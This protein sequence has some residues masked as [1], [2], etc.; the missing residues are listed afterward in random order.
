MIIDG[1]I[2]QFFRNFFRDGRAQ[3]FL[4]VGDGGETENLLMRYLACYDKS[5]CKKCEACQSESFLGARVYEG[6]S[7]KIEDAR[8]IQF[9]AN[10][11]A[12][13]G[14]KI[15]RIKSGYLAPDAQTTLLKTI[16]EPHPE[17]Y[18]VISLASDASLSLP[19]L[20]RLTV[21]KKSK[22]DEKAEISKF[23]L[24]LE[25][26]GALAQNRDEAEEVFRK[27]EAW[28]EPKIR[29]LNTD[30][31]MLFSGFVEDYFQIKKR[32]FERTYSPKMLL[33]HLALSKHYI[34]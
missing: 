31:A 27:I 28:M 29:T 22:Q 14:S 30:S 26:I 20:S 25:D 12:L 5:F 2:N 7:L 24:N 21:F 15:F 11:T 18:F 8:E 3:A 6:E 10:Q 17:T 33:E 4:L 9:A 34:E 16:E 19:L 1:D 32:F 13:Y 23:K